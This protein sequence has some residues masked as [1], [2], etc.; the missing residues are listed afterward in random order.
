LVFTVGDILV[1]FRKWI[2]EQPVDFTIKL[3]ARIIS[4]ETFI[5]QGICVVKGVGEKPSNKISL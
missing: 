4:T 1:D 3:S 2:T 5:A